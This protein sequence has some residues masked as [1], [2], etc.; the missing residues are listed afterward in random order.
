[1]LAS[2][3][4]A[5]DMSLGLFFLLCAAVMVPIQVIVGP[6][7]LGDVSFEEHQGKAAVPWRPIILIGLGLLFA[8]I[9]ESA[10]TNWSAVFLTDEVAATEA[11]AALGYGVYS[12]VLLVCRVFIDRLDMRVGPVAI[13]RASAVIG[14]LAVVIIV[15]AP[16]PAIA[17]VGFAVLG[18]SVAPVFPLAFTAGASHDPDRSGR[19]VARVNI[20]NYA[21]VL[22]GAPLIGVVAE[23]SDLR[24]GFAILIFAPVVVM[25]V[26][27]SYRTAGV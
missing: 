16:S 9:L 8:S 21:G 15:V 14:V 20:F 24:I 6:R 25:A 5:I 10:A 17:L 23:F 27:R 26:A 13:M 19:A 22:L 12:L 18:L 11:I 2:A 4:A 7:L 1:M 3:A